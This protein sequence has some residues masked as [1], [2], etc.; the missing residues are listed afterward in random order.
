MGALVPIIAGVA[1]A[2]ASELSFTWLCFNSA[3]ASNLGSAA[4]AVYG[5][6]VMSRGS[7]GENMD[8]AN[9]YAMLTV[10]ATVMMIP[11]TLAIE[12]PTAIVKG[13]QAAYANGG[14]QILWDLIYS[15][16]YFYMYNEVAFQALG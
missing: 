1:L 13:F 4:R 5:K 6:K 11:L 14:P 16:L 12:G 9:V 2:S 15:G 10:L 7:I 8:A 3:M